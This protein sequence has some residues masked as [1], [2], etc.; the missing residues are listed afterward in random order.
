[1]F[2]PKGQFGQSILMKESQLFKLTPFFFPSELIRNSEN[3]IHYKKVSAELASLEVEKKNASDFLMLMVWRQESKRSTLLVLLQK[4]T[5]I[6]ENEMQE[7]AL[8]GLS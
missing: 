6:P 7:I 4:Q 3:V 1:M 8:L 5:S 2:F